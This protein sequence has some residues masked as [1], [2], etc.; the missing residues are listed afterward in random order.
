[1][2]GIRLFEL[3]IKLRA[4][5]LDRESAWEK[6]VQS[7]AK[8]IAE[9]AKASLTNAQN[10][11]IADVDAGRLPGTGQHVPDPDSR[12]NT[13]DEGGPPPLRPGEDAPGYRWVAGLR[14]IDEAAYDFS[15]H[16][17]DPESP[18]CRALAE[19]ELKAEDALE[20][21]RLEGDRYLDGRVWRFRTTPWRFVVGKLQTEKAMPFSK[22]DL[23]EAVRLVQV[24]QPEAVPLKVRQFLAEQD[25]N[26]YTKELAAELW[27]DYRSDCDAIGMPGG[28]PLIESLVKLEKAK[29]AR[30]HTITT[31]AADRLLDDQDFREEVLRARFSN[32]KAA[33][34][35]DLTFNADER[36]VL[37]EFASG[38][39]PFPGYR[40][41]PKL[42]SAMLLASSAISDELRESD[43]EEYVARGGSLLDWHHH[44]D[45]PLEEYVFERVNAKLS[46]LIDRPAL[47]VFIIRTIEGRAAQHE[48]T[49]WALDRLV[50]D[51]FADEL[52]REVWQ[53]YRVECEIQRLPG[54]TPTRTDR[55]GGP[56][57]EGQEDRAPNHTEPHKQRKPAW[58]RL[59]IT[60]QTGGDDLAELDG[61]SHRI[62]SKAAKFLRSLQAKRGNMILG[63][64]LKDA[65]GDRADRIFNSLP[66]ELQA[67]VERPGKGKSGYRML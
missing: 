23:F 5:Q 8:V 11:L 14:E 41:G 28:N 57:P 18:A 2:P 61:R 10:A 54:P 7:R 1:M 13:G 59:K 58:Q 46:E 36:R 67:I 49:R 64:T 62:T 48:E 50:A 63:A 44:G 47:H 40:V 38:E 3:L 21:R 52:L 29:R 43:A 24:E 31:T 22:A 27:R 55:G 6:A 51:G 15:L 12:T 42:H 56:T 45:N 53:R 35:K 20:W 4:D 30:D 26:G 17:R 37:R 65:C 66:P 34:R 39:I 16:R 33:K 32:P 19:A 9:R 60:E 25:D